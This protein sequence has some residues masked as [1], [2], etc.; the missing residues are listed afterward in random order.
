MGI[1]RHISEMASD[2]FTFPFPEVILWVLNQFSLFTL[3]FVSVNYTDQIMLRDP[4]LLLDC[5][6]LPAE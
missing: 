1:V 4:G 2:M 6:K 5:E 3:S